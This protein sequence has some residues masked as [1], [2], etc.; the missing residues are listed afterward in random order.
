M[1]KIFYKSLF[2]SF[3]FLF[4]GMQGVFAANTGF[5][6]NNIWLSNITPLAGDIIKINSVIVNDDDRSFGGRII[7]LDNNLAISNEIP[8]E[9]QGNG[10]SDVVFVSWEAIQGEHW[11]KAVIE[12]AYFVES[13]GVHTSVDASMMS[14]STELIYVDIDSD[15]D[16]IGDQT[17]QNQG[18][19]PNNADTDGDGEDDG[20]D[21][22]P[23]DSTVFGGSDTDGDGISDAVDSD[24]D[25]DGLY[26]WEE[27]SLGTD[28]KKYDTDGDGYND[29]EDG[30]PLDNKKWEKEVISEI[31]NIEPNTKQNLLP[32]DLQEQSSQEDLISEDDASQVLGEKIYTQKISQNN[33]FITSLLIFTTFLAL[34]FLLL[35]IFFFFYA[36][37]KKTEEEQEFAEKE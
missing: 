27:S 18:T 20:E 16:G 33:P 32:S 5:V 21:P 23:T 4:F 1:I 30:Y 25:N 34:L 9:L 3:L 10:A 29:K 2:L 26:N 13:D 12:N 22:N 19:D 17:E 15:G 35:G 11:F 7:F 6:D 36:K 14:Q 31:L 37:K 24:Q 28:S 8:F